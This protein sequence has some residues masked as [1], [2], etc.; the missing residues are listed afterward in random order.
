LFDRA[1]TSC[2]VAT[3]AKLRG[4]LDS[5]VSMGPLWIEGR[6]L[7]RSD[8]QRS[9]A[10]DFNAWST[11]TLKTSR[12]CGTDL[13]LAAAPVTV[14]FWQYKWVDTT[15]NPETWQ[16]DAKNPSF[17]FDSFAGNVDGKNSVLNTPGSGR[18]NLIA[19]GQLCST[20]LGNCRNLTA[21]LPPDYTAASNAERTYPTLFMHDGQNVFDDTSCCFG[22]TGW[23][24]N[25]AFDRGIATHKV[26]PAIV[27]AVD[28]AGAERNNEYGWLAAAG[29]KIETYASF[30]IGQV[31]PNAQTL[32]VDSN[33]RFIAGSSLGGLVS[34]HIALA[35]PTTFIGAASI[36]GAFWPGQD[37]HTAMRDLLPTIGKKPVGIYLDH[38]GTMA[39]GGDGLQDSIDVRNL[40][41]GLG[42]TQQTSPTCSLSNSSLC[43]HHELGATHDE[44]AWRA[45]VWR[46]LEFFFPAN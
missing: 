15:T 33:K 14:G 35:H 38:G 19:L 22:H 41:V 44:L 29:G 27:I 5:R 18:G 12:L 39:S 32:R 11:S 23:E 3:I 13:Y 28:N 24:I 45:R 30:F 6:A 31:V 34:L 42:W 26:A 21:Y 1:Q 2:D 16:L 43:Y 25:L 10:G 40:M 7:F 8:G 46:M 36:S 9:I 37:S 17:A 4:E 20:A